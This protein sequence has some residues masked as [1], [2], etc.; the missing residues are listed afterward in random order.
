M[1][2]C[3]AR[4]VSG[5]VMGLVFAVVLV[6][7]LSH[8]SATT[9]TDAIAP[10]SSVATPD[11]PL[12]NQQPE[13]TPDTSIETTT[14]VSTVDGVR[15]TQ[16]CPAGSD[17]VDAN[18]RRFTATQLA[19]TRRAVAKYGA[20]VETFGGSALRFVSG[21]EPAGV[22]IA[23]FTDEPA[24]HAS[25]LAALEGNGRGLVV[26]R[27]PFTNRQATQI[28]REIRA[29]SRIRSIAR[30]GDIVA[31][32]LTTKQ[33]DVAEELAVRYGPGL[34][35]VVGR[36][37]YPDG[38]VPKPS[39]AQPV[40]G[41]LP[42]ATSAQTKLRW[43]LPSNIRKAKDVDLNALTIGLSN[44]SR[45]PLV[46]TNGLSIRGLITSKDGDEILAFATSVLRTSR[47]PGI[48]GEIQLAG[49]RVL[50]VRPPLNFDSCRPGSGWTLPPGSYS[51][52]V[53][54]SAIATTS[55]ANG[56]TVTSAEQRTDAITTA[57][58]ITVVSPPISLTIVKGQ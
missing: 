44:T 40:C 17:A 13:G 9:P 51:Y 12:S 8:S 35:I 30:D 39:L 23:A 18:G 32:A 49:T 36:L 11:A 14:T 10:Q 31:V 19:A 41:I 56:A 27:S 7:P 48:A 43:K 42:K 46:F 22:V 33:L 2:C 20:T 58:L 34:T 3:Q 50:S 28:V 29:D 15:V 16:E 38:S 4:G 37:T 26:C 5:A 1:R 21:A 52:R 55:T 45:Q 6:S 57:Q 25:A 24:V 54:L 47:E 53:A